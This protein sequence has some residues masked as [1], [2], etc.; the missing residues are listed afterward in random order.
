[1]S[2]SEKEE[3]ILNVLLSQ[4]DQTAA[5]RV[6]SW[7][8]KALPKFKRVKTKDDIYR[9]IYNE[10]RE[11]AQ[12]HERKFA[13]KSDFEDFFQ[14]AFSE[15]WKAVERG[16][17]DGRANPGTYFSTILVRKFGNYE[18]KKRNNNLIDTND[19]ALNYEVSDNPNA[20]DHLI[21]ERTKEILRK[22]ADSI[23]GDCLE[24]LQLFHLNDLTHEEVEAILQSGLATNP[25]RLSS[26]CAQRFRVFFCENPQLLGEIEGF[27]KIKLMLTKRK[28]TIRFIKDKIGENCSSLLNLGNPCSIAGGKMKSIL[29]SAKTSAIDPHNAERKAKKDCQS[30]VL[31]IFNQ[32]PDFMNVFGMK[33]END[34]YKSLIS[35]DDEESGEL[36]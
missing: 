8:R 4:R 1:M 5:E 35:T 10:L 36:Y 13:N 14:E 22:A 28:E 21:N 23:G 16:Q 34:I 11:K 30:K 20:L 25:R 32:N 19:S 26:N 9:G 7:I 27:E 18:Q 3:S 33:L 12:Y 15:F 2:L 29:N 6:L 31:D 24:R 17:Y